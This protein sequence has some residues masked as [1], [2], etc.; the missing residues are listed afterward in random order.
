MVPAHGMHGSDPIVD[1]WSLSLCDSIVEGSSTYSIWAAIAGGRMVEA[2]RNR[3]AKQ[4]QQRDGD[5]QIALGDL[6]VPWRQCSLRPPIASLSQLVGDPL[7]GPPGQGCGRLAV[8]WW[9]AQR[10]AWTGP[11]GITDGLATAESA[12]EAA[13]RFRK[14]SDEYQVAWGGKL[15]MKILGNR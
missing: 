5:T 4:V 7:L 10:A 3:I 1:L 2:T 12:V 9:H 14:A 13:A 15:G 8:E 6:A 11:E